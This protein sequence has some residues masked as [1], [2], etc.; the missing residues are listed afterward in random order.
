VRHEPHRQYRLIR[1]GRFG[2]KAGDIVYLFTGCTY[3][4]IDSR[5]E[6]AMSL[7]DGETP[8]QGVDYDNLEVVE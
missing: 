8:F 2:F 6:V 7:V 5:T 3:G 4:C 1:D